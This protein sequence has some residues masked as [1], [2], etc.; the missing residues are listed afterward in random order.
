MEEKQVQP[1]QSLPG[2][3]AEA[4]TTELFQIEEAARRTGLTTRTLRYYEE[5]KLVVPVRRGDSNYRLYTQTDLERIERVRQLKDLLSFSLDEIRELLEVGEMR[6]SLRQEFRASTDP[7]EK[8]R[9]LVEAERLSQRELSLI[10]DKLQ[11]LEK[12]KQETLARIERHHKRL[13]QL[14]NEL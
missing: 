3:L 11:R 1:N 9:N 2:E 14:E 7:T 4:E 5:K 12:L 8:H 10:E 13:A 6:L